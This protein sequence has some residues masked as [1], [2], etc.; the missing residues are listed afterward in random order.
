MEDWC[1]LMTLPLSEVIRPMG[2][3]FSNCFILSMSSSDLEWGSSEQEQGEQQQE[4]HRF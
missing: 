3:K 4:K 2:S 1:T